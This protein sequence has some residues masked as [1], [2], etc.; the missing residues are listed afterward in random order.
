MTKDSVDGCAD[1]EVANRRVRA[2]TSAALALLVMPAT[3]CLVGHV[4]FVQHGLE[5]LGKSCCDTNVLEQVED[6]GNALRGLRLQ[7]KN[8][9]LGES[10]KWVVG[11]GGGVGGDRVRIDMLF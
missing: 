9:L 1:D 7:T 3:I 6:F 4:L 8:H 2:A 5:C 10:R 11:G